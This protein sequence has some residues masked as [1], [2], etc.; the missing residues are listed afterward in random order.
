MLRRTFKGSPFTIDCSASSMPS[1]SDLQSILSSVGHV[2]LRG[3]EFSDGKQLESQFGHLIGKPMKYKGGTGERVPID[4][5]DNALAAGYEPPHLHLVQHNEMS[6][7]DQWPHLFM[8]ACIGNT[9][10]PDQGITAICDNRKLTEHLPTELRRKYMELGIRYIRNEI[11]SRDPDVPSETRKQFISWQKS[12][13]TQNA[14]DVERECESK[15]Y[16][17]SW[18]QDGSLSYVERISLS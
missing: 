13:L 10:P 14:E 8:L 6:Y 9:L 15:G 1:A 4:A 17:F 3:L 16:A 11:D 5:S 12:F 2:R 7:T 18:N